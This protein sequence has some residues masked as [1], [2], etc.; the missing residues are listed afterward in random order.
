MSVSASLGA[1][2]AHLADQLHPLAGGSAT[3]AA[4]V[5]LTLC[6]RLALHPFTRAAARGEK[7]RAALAPRIAE[8][9]RK[10][11]RDPERLRRATAELFAE[12]GTSP[13]AGYLPMLA[14]LPVFFV[15]YR[16]FAHGGGDV[17]DHSLFGAPLSGRWAD[18]LADG[19]LFGAQ[20]LVYLGLFAV[21]AAVATWTYLRA[22]KGATAVD[23][24]TAG[25]ARTGVAKAGTAGAGTARASRAR[26]AE[27]DPAA[28][29][30]AAMAR[31]LPLLSFGTLLAAAFVP[32]AAGLYLATTTAW[33]AAERAWLHRGNGNGNGSGNGNGNDN[34]GRSRTGPRRRTGN[35]EVMRTATVK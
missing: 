3:A 29:V 34:G 2:L 23:G 19:G 9:Q 22:R 11:R 1:L 20:G 15:M 27:G 6:V 8:L 7:A 10:H 13:L 16:L 24:A 35:R 33:S 26:G 28:S 5:L 21:I 31:V 12:T 17:L 25:A 30:P 18:A 4:I 32:L 14:Q